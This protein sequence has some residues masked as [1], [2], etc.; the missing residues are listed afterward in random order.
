LQLITTAD[1][2]WYKGKQKS[3]LLYKADLNKIYQICLKEYEIT[4]PAASD[5]TKHE[6]RGSSCD[7]TGNSGITGGG[8]GAGALCPK[9]SFINSTTACKFKS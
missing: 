5:S 9:C 3:I 7:G 2:F 4:T 6:K 1:C 8:W